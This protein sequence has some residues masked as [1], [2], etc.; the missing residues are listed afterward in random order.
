MAEWQWGS[1][2]KAVAMTEQDAKS[3]VDRFVEAV[4]A[5][6]MAEQMEQYKQ[7]V[8]TESELADAR[9]E[10]ARLSGVEQA[11][12]AH[13]GQLQ[14]MISALT[15]APG[16]IP[17]NPYNNNG[18]AQTGVIVPTFGNHVAASAPIPA[19]FAPVILNGEVPAAS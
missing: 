3:M 17:F 15:P 5:H 2:K 18:P 19:Q 12:R 4:T 7:H 1:D 6:R 10:I 13:I 8:K 14:G 9:R 11:L 16:A